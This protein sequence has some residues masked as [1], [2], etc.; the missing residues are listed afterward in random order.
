MTQQQTM[1]KTLHPLDI[2][3]QLDDF[4]HMQDGWLEGE[5]LAPSHDG[6]DWLTATFTQRYQTEL[7]LPYIYPTPERR[8]TCR[9]SAIQRGKPR[10]RP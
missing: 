2:P 7:P 4:R 3:A 8:S 6:L 10:N 5:G 9:I 1:A